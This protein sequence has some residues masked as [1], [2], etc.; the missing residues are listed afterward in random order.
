MEGNMF[1]CIHEE[2]EFIKCADGSVEYKGG[3]TNCIIVNENVSYVD[4]ISKVC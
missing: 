1:C 4:F 3:R 2:D